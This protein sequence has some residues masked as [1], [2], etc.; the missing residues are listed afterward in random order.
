MSLSTIYKRGLAEVP[1]PHQPYRL[2]TP[3]EGSF[4]ENSP[5]FGFTSGTPLSGGMNQTRVLRQRVGLAG[6]PVLPGRR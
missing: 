6:Q 5:S 4:R 2:V 1:I 3:R